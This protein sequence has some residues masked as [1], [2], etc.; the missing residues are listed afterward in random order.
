MYTLVR[1]KESFVS[2]N[3]LWG[4]TFCGG[5]FCGWYVLWQYVFVRG[6]FVGDTFGCGDVLWRDVLD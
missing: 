5:T 2:W 4:G 3:I 1:T 6:R